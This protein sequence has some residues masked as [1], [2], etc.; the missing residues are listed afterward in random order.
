M[1]DAKLAAPNP[2]F[3]SYTLSKYALAGLTEVA[4]RA[5]AGKGIRVNAHR[6]GADAAVGRAGRG[7]F[8]RGPCA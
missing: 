4:A 2:D 7:E 1:L 3:L 8:R 5:L 6:A